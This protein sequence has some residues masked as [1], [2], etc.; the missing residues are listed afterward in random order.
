MPKRGRVDA[1]VATASPLGL[2]SCVIE[3]S[4]L[5]SSSRPAGTDWESST[6]EPLLS[7]WFTM[8][9]RFYDA[10]LAS[11]PLANITGIT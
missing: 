3:S 5:L 2:P 10:Q 4:P 11:E 6:Y 9:P 8:K 1:T 7:V